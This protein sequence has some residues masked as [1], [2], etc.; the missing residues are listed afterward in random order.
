MVSIEVSAGKH[1]R[2]WKCKPCGY[3]GRSW[4]LRITCTRNTYLLTTILFL[5]WRA[6]PSKLTLNTPLPEL[7][8]EED[9]QL[10]DEF[11]VRKPSTKELELKETESMKRESQS[12]SLLSQ[13]WG[14]GRVNRLCRWFT[15]AMR[16]EK[17]ATRFRKS[18]APSRKSP[19]KLQSVVQGPWPFF[20][21][22]GSVRGTVRHWMTYSSLTAPLQKDWQETLEK[23]L[24]IYKLCHVDFMQVFFI[25]DYSLDVYSFD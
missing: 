5:L 11:F 17:R 8:T 3:R 21:S 25:L 9:Q 23:C 18:S 1:G 10:L 15:M 2:A 24:S 19:R 14:E 13:L 16:K 22:L 4:P 20:Q 6:I 7:L 12:T